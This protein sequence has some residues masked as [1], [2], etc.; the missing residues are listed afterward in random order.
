M[1]EGG[2]PRAATQSRPSRR[3]QTAKAADH[4]FV[5]RAMELFEAPPDKLRYTPPDETQ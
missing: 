4:P 3:E 1:A 2:T 5:R